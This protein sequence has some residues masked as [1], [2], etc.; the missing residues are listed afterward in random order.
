MT[1][2]FQAEG[3]VKRFGKTTALAGVFRRFREADLRVPCV[4]QVKERRL[5]AGGVATST[6][7]RRR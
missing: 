7:R 5:P 3:L 4:V 1:Y 6:S 2:A